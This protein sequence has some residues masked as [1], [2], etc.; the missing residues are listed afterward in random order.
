MQAVPALNSTAECNMMQACSQAPAVPAFL[1]AP[2]QSASTAQKPHAMMSS[3]TDDDN[4]NGRDT[5]N[6]MLKHGVMT[7]IPRSVMS[8]HYGMLK[9]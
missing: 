6:A 5:D 8:H 3:I 7:G 2:V 9:S 1:Q 4:E